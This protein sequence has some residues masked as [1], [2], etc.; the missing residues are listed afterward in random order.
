[1]PASHSATMRDSASG[2]SRTLTFCRQ[3]PGSSADAVAVTASMAAAPAA[4]VAPTAA[5]MR[6]GRL[7]GIIGF[8]LRGAGFLQRIPAA[9]FCTVGQPNERRR[10]RFA[11]WRTDHRKW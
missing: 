1:M 8:G 5:A 3:R 9:G 10:Y 2:S 6:A 7:R 11:T 4:T